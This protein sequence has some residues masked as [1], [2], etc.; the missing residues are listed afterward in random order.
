MYVFV[1]I[2]NKHPLIHCNVFV[3]LLSGNVS[4]IWLNEIVENA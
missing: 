1:F 4:N 3:L 2:L